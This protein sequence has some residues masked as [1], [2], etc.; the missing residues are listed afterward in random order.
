MLIDFIEIDGLELPNDR[1]LKLVDGV[2][3]LERQN[4][5]LL[6]TGEIGYVVYQLY[7]DETEDVVYSDSLDLPINSF[8]FTSEIKTSLTA[9]GESLTPEMEDFLTTIY[10]ELGQ[11]RDRKRKRRPSKKQ[12]NEPE[13][14]HGTTI[15]ETENEVLDELPTEVPSKPKKKKK[16]KP[17]KIK[18]EKSFSLSQILSGK[19]KTFLIAAAVFFLL[20]FL[21]FGAIKW[22]PSLFADRA[23]SYEELLKDE[24][25]S[26]AARSYPDR[27][28]EIEQH[29]YDKALDKQSTET[30]KELERFQEKFPTPF[31][32]FD[33]AILNKNY[34]QALSLYKKKTKAFKD[35]KDRMTLVGY[36]YL[37]S[38][39]PKEA[40][41]ISHELKSVELEKYVYKYEQLVAQIEEY[42][43]RLE[44]LKKDPVKN[45]DKIEQTLNDLFDSKEELVNL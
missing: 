12:I 7:F 19:L 26:E 20:A 35:S 10:K 42:E 34:D 16:N 1:R 6:S 2:L 40:K 24:K 18:K 14:D 38:D 27:K 39:K 36:C 45:R 22:L 31:G 17:K 4:E 30:E 41:E 23:P 33:L 28:Q 37:K 13:I 29:L 44:D 11:K 8:N 15:E 5:E 21:G 32:D 3:L 9:D 25:Y 43:K